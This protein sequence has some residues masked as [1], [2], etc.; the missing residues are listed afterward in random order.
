MR[1]RNRHH[2]VTTDQSKPLPLL[3]SPK[4]SPPSSSLLQRPVVSR[5]VLDIDFPVSSCSLSPWRPPIPLRIQP[6]VWRKR[7]RS[8]EWIRIWDFFHCPF[9]LILLKFLLHGINFTCFPAPPSWSPRNDSNC[10]VSSDT[11]A[12]RLAVKPTEASRSSNNSDSSRAVSAAKVWLVCI[13]L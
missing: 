3:Q 2:R 6:S 9:C 1:F 7:I 5:W 10:P 13:A 12:L 11:L 8:M 4:S